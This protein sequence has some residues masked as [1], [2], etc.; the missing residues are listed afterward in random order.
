M[1]DKIRISGAVAELLNEREL[2]I[3]I[4]GSRCLGGDEIYCP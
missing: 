2:A 1:S 4:G 3:N